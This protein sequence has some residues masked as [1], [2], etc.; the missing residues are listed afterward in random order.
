[1]E[2]ARLSVSELVSSLPPLTPPELSVFPPQE[3]LAAALTCDAFAPRHFD[4]PG[5]RF[6]LPTV[7]ARMCFVHEPV[8]SKKHDVQRDKEDGIF[9]REVGSARLEAVNRETAGKD[10]R[11]ALHVDFRVDRLVSLADLVDVDKGSVHGPQIWPAGVAL[12][13]HLLSQAAS[14]VRGLRV[15]EIGCGWALPSL[16]CAYMGADRVVSSDLP[17]VVTSLRQCLP[18]GL[19]IVAE[20]WDWEV[21]DTCQNRSKRGDAVD[22][23]LCAD[24]VYAPLYEP[25]RLLQALRTL[26]APTLLAVERRPADGLE[27]LL[28]ALANVGGQVSTASGDEGDGN[29]DRALGDSDDGGGFLADLVA[30]YGGSANDKGG[31]P[32]DLGGAIV[33]IWELDPMWPAG[34]SETSPPARPSRSRS[35][36]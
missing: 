28:T 11:A 33:E 36:S 34:A 1:M 17:D 27:A 10:Q 20:T 32:M 25:T 30:Q 7:D 26:R 9:Y 22:L 3:K 13:D 29:G 21:K 2:E 12:A 14:R 19:P 23:V 8:G 4:F 24:C 31:P 35:R 15:H 16:A 5:R 6:V 18:R